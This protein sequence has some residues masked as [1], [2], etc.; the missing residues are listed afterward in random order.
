MEAERKEAGFRSRSHLH[1]GQTASRQPAT[2]AQKREKRPSNERQ[3]GEEFA[4][5]GVIMARSLLVKTWQSQQD[6][7]G[8]WPGMSVNPIGP[9]NQ[10]RGFWILV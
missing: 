7:I 6:E 9:S 2:V 8:G 10:E 4:L 5:F 1:W 3:R